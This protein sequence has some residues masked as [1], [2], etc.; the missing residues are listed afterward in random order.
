MIELSSNT[1]IMLYLSLTLGV[2]LVFWGYH[3]YH[4]RRNKIE[5][6]HNRLIVCEYCHT[7]Y[8]DLVEKQ[9]TQCPKCRSYNRRK[10]NPP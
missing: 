9:V 10:R 7:A 4:S 8:L 6:V 1:A 2:L 5:F 3:H